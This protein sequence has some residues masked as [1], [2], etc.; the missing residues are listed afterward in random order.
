MTSWFRYVF[1]I[2]FVSGGGFPSL[3]FLPLSYSGSFILVGPGCCVFNP[4][5]LLQVKTFNLLLINI[6]FWRCPLTFCLGKC[7]LQGHLIHSL[8]EAGCHLPGTWRWWL[9][10]EMSVSP[11]TAAKGVRGMN[12][13]PFLVS[14]SCWQVEQW[15]G[16]PLERRTE[17]LY[18]LYLVTPV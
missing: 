2:S 3:S 14:Q 12:W 11:N 17:L 18:L 1:T 13:I 7:N 10:H 15:Q 4:S 9:R 6:M 8:T 5:C 16:D